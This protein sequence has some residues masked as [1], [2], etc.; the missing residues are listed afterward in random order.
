MGAEWFFGVG[1]LLNLHRTV[2]ELS[3]NIHK[4]PRAKCRRFSYNIRIIG[5]QMDNMGGL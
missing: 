5:D 1:L 3:P 2:T 4:S